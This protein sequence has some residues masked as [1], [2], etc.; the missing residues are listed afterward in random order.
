MNY[1]L[2]NIPSIE[3]RKRKNRVKLNL[4]RLR[5]EININEDVLRKLNFE[6]KDRN[7]DYD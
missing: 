2:G 7:E 6:L 1:I 3:L 5:H 4:S